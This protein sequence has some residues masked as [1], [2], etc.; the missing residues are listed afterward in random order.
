V[1]ALQSISKSFDGR[2]VLA[3]LE[4]E[5]AAGEALAIVGP[6]GSGKSTLL[7]ILGLMLSPDSG[8]YTLAGRNVRDVSR[9]AQA[10]IRGTV[11]G[12]VFQQFHLIRTCDVATNVAVPLAYTGVAV[13]DRAPLV[14]S[15]LE[16]VGM[17][18][19]AKQDVRTLS[20]GE[21]QRVALARALIRRPS[22]LLCD[23]PTGNLDPANAKIVLDLMLEH[24]ADGGTVVVITHDASV[25]AQLGRSRRL[26]DGHLV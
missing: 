9:R 18:H 2:P 13:A 12:F 19:A 5:V 3:D 6:S 17:A 16:R 7:G 1:I 11:L 14:A 26:V 4:L 8:L 24:A 25:A 10:E 15:M 21:Q 23:E 20:G 22:V